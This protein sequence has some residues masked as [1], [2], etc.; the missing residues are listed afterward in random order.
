MIP[1]AATLRIVIII[2]VIAIIIIAV[3]VVD[4]NTIIIIVN[5]SSSHAWRPSRSLG[6]AAAAMS[7]PFIPPI[8]RRDSSR[9]RG[10]MGRGGEKQR[11]VRRSTP[12]ERDAMLAGS[13]GTRCKGL[14]LLA[15]CFLLG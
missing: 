8:S 6:F 7:V 13:G 2:Y 10:E 5:S 12:L 9:E 3:I 11:D 4:V 15:C 14:L 1:R